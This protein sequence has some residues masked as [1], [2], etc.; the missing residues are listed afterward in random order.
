MKIK[1]NFWNCLFIKNN[2]KTV[3][4]FKAIVDKFKKILLQVIIFDALQFD[5]KGGTNIKLSNQNSSNIWNSKI[6]K[7]R[8]KVEIKKMTQKLKVKKII[9]KRLTKCIVC[10]KDFL[11]W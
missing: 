8:P 6:E 11:L 1:K 3:I 9:N 4:N 5:K 2:F 10:R 7:T